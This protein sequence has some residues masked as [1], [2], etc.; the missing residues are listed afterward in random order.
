MTVRASAGGGPA[1]RRQRTGRRRLRWIVAAVLVAAAALPAL[2]VTLLGYR[3]TSALLERNVIA[4]LTATQDSR[5]KAIR[6]GFEQR[7]EAVAILAADTAVV[8]SLLDFRDAVEELAE[9]AAPL[10]TGEPAEPGG[11]VDDVMRGDVRA[12][13]EAL[14]S[15]ELL[16]A[17]LTAVGLAMPP[18]DELLPDRAGTYLQYH[19][20][21]NGPAERALVDDPGDGSTY[22][23]VHAQRHPMLRQ[24][25][26]DLGARDLLLVTF[27]QPR[28][29]YSVGKD[30]DFATDLGASAFADSD[31]LTVLT[32]ELPRVTVGEAVMV[33]LQPYLGA[34][35]EPMVFVAA[36]VLDGRELVGAV[37]AQFTVEPLDEL[38]TT[39]GRWVEVGLGET[40]ETYVV[41]RDLRLRS[42]P[43]GWLEDPQAHLDRLRA[44]GLGDVAADVEVAGSPV[45][46]ER[47]DTPHTRSALDGVRFAGRSTDANGR[48]VFAT[49]SPLGL[50]TLDWV[51]VA[52]V[53]RSEATADSAG[54]LRTVLLVAAV[55]IPSVAAAGIALTRRLTRPVAT[56][57]VAA[58]AVAAGDLDVRVADAAG[59]EFGHLA[60]EL[61][62]YAAALADEEAELRGQRR[63]VDE[64]LG[65]LLPPRGI[66]AVVRG[67]PDA[68]DATAAVT[69]VAVTLDGMPES[70]DSWSFEHVV[71]IG[72]RLEQLAVEH[73][74]Q[75]VWSSLDRHLF[76]AGFEPADADAAG[77]TP[78]DDGAAEALA[79]VAAIMHVPERFDRADDSTLDL[80]VALAAGGIASGVVGGRQVSYGVTGRP[81]WLAMALE[82]I[83]VPG[84][85]LIHES[86]LA[87]L[88]PAVLD[89]LPG[90]HRPI[91]VEA[92]GNEL[93]V[94]SLEVP[95]DVAG[96]LPT[97]G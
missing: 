54:Q 10:A 90:E 57:L 2:V 17:R 40:G 52:E 87:R 32:D 94:L 44:R 26:A 1:D 65:A 20:V 59:D 97:D 69:V 34:A 50:G 76:I 77:S 16:G 27:E 53:T 86:V 47:V 8:G 38:M 64:L 49:A 21:V 35:G 19:Y 62:R 31:L 92:F 23:A 78:A 85:V 95:V 74:L 28:V 84:R 42:D 45:L 5:I 55:L 82:S 41:G 96:E 29:V 70:V 81:V 25:A 39:G 46:V 24:R 4:E 36:A 37:I 22:S 89:Q 9:P 13:Y 91:T 58:E 12:F 83:G 68:C 75:R 6:Q 63:A 79:F 61:E 80:H 3:T 33:D 88:D 71:A 60:R 48:E 56:L 14:V 7:R 51:V 18:L 67:A 73:R 11:V 72:T 15:D 66:D 93:T 30:P 43:R